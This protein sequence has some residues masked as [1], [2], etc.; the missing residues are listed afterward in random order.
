MN[1]WL[2][3][4]LASLVLA[5]ALA[6][7]AYDPPVLEDLRALVFDQYQRAAPRE[8]KPAPVKVVDIDDESLARLGQWPWPR[9]VM[10]ELLAKLR[11]QGVAAVALDIVYA[12]PDRT[13]PALVMPGW[14]LSASDPL[15]A[16]LEKRIKSP[17]DILAEEMARGRVVIGVS[18]SDTSTNYPLVRKA[19]VSKIKGQGIDPA[20]YLVSYEGAIASLPPLQQ[21][22]A[23]IGNIN[24][25][26][27]R[28][29]VVRRVPLL[30]KGGDTIYPSLA[31]EAL[32]VA[33]G[34]KNYVIKASGA[35][36]TWLVGWRDGIVGFAVGKASNLPIKTDPRAQVWL[37]DTGHQPERFVPAWQ[38][39]AGEADLGGQIVFI[40]T[41]APGLKDLRTTPNTSAVPGVEIHAQIV[42]QILSGDFLE[43]PLWATELELAV[44]L[45]LGLALVSL[46][47]RLGA[48][49][50][51]ILGGA[52]I[53]AAIAFGWWAFLDRGWLF[54][55]AYP[56]AGA[57]AVFTTGVL[58]SFRRSDL[59]RKRIRETF[60]HYL[61]PAMVKR[62]V[63]NPGLLKLGG[64][65]RDLTIM[66]CDIRDFTTISER[67]EAS[68]LTALLND[69]LTP[70]TEAVLENDGTIDKYIGDS[71]MAFWNAPLDEPD[72]AELAC[73]A[74]LE[75]RRRL[76]LLNAQLAEQ[77]AKAGQEHQ[78]IMIGIGLN[79]G[80]AM[81]GNLGARQRLNYSV[82]G[83]N[84]N[85]ASRIEGVS[86]SFG[87]DILIGEQTRAAAPDFAA[88]PIGDIQVKGKTR[89]ARLFALIG[90]PDVARAPQAEALLAAFSDA[91]QGFKSG[92]LAAVESALARAR[93]L[94]AGL[95]LDALLDHMTRALAGARKKAAA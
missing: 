35:Q 34:E 5:L 66:F 38:V 54:D 32:R 79:S 29:G 67:M 74:T 87:V 59:E 55:P 41:S 93:E 64:E 63:A 80:P 12:E 51:A 9:S 13:A 10:A 25:V 6:L 73:K 49:G 22:A 27:D 69:F 95:G 39:L 81:V 78:P 70:M 36:G 44:L 31:A 45:V 71:I 86:K 48:I 94:G 58:L 50:S 23:G 33:L 14:G 75:M 24:T 3:P 40:G 19:G 77:A 91:A 57:L 17:D 53:L 15:V 42:E 21:A 76:A 1:K 88:I 65:V 47:P 72:H 60:S 28:D 46:M 8:F 30:V 2:Q 16:E 26:Y 18:M 90:G 85:L 4:A 61:A 62:L 84:V 68:A 20:D 52:S 82:I 83:D 11:E 7:R 56:S 89:P 43:R 92:D 37:R